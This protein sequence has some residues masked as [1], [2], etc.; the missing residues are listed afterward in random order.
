MIFDKLYI[1]TDSPQ[2]EA[3]HE[4]FDWPSVRNIDHSIDMGKT[5]LQLLQILENH[6][7]NLIPKIILFQLNHS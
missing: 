6:Q 7:T 5:L 1:G 2:C 4:Q 3:A